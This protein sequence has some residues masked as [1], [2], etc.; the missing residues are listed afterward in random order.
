MLADQLV[1]CLTPNVDSQ[2]RI[3]AITA[4]YNN[5]TMFFDVWQTSSCSAVIDSLRPTEKYYFR[6]IAVNSSGCRGLS[7]VSRP[8]VLSR[9]NSTRQ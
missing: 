5:H 9:G 1:G 3:T 7:S 4:R 2:Q 8:F 6:L